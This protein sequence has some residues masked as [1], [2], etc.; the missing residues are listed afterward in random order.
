MTHFLLCVA[1]CAIPIAAFIV[2]LAETRTDVGL[3]AVK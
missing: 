1:A 3:L 2:Y